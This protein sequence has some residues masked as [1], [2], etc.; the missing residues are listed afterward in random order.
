[1]I[2]IDDATDLL[3]ECIEGLP[4]DRADGVLLL[5]VLHGHGGDD[6]L[7]LGHKLVLSHLFSFVLNL[8]RHDPVT[9]LEIPLP[10]HGC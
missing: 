2:V 4:A 6:N 3:V 5:L 7:L 8:V 10:K 9:L 1:M